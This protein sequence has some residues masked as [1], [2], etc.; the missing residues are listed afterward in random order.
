MQPQAQHGYKDATSI[1][2]NKGRFALSGNRSQLP[3]ASGL[4]TQLGINVETRGVMKGTEIVGF[5]Q[6]VLTQ[7]IVPFEFQKSVNNFRIDS[8]LHDQ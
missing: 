8:Y 7:M 5:V 6:Y 3:A 2:I 1:Y 4:A